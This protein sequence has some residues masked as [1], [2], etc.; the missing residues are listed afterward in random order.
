MADAL[1]M[2]AV[3]LAGVSVRF[4]ARSVLASVELGLEPGE[5][6]AL[7]GPNGAG[8]ST[9][10]RV[11]AGLL[12]PAAGT[13]RVLG[14]AP[15]AARAGGLI[16]WCAGGE[17][18]WT[19]RLSL[20][21]CL[22]FHATVAG[23]GSRQASARIHDLA[24]RFGF[25]DH[26]DLSAD[27]CSTGIRQRAALAR[28]LLHRPPIV[29]LDEPLRGV[30]AASRDALL[31]ELRDELEGRTTIWVSHS[32]AELAAVSRR[33]ATLAEGVLHEPPRLCSAAWSAPSAAWSAPSA[34]WSAP[35][36]A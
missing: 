22:A 21:R 24:E 12:A 30:D 10:L 11:I 7:S 27:R 17:A 18:S 35:S 6:L 20:G 15:E 34:A 25:R 3:R 4:G 8:K 33:A 16:G 31:T 9:L 13:V 26:L 29:L 1:R 32:P 36:T 5:A 28:A 23:L 14:G 19:R 2:D